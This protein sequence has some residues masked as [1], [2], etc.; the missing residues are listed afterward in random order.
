[1]TTNPPQVAGVFAR[2]YKI[3]AT[4]IL[5][6]LH[7]RKAEAARVAKHYTCPELGRTCTRIGAYDAYDLPSLMGNAEMP[8]RFAKELTKDTPCT[9]QNLNALL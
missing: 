1:M 4:P 9:S 5:D 3:R 6:E 2:P 8:Y 7:R